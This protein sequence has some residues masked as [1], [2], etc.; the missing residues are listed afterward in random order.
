M[1][2]SNSSST[3]GYNDY[4]ANEQFIK[5][6]SEKL[7]DLVIVFDFKKEKLIYVNKRLA[8]I[9]NYS[10]DDLLSQEK[11]IFKKLFFPNEHE[12]FLHKIKDIKIDDK[13][14][15]EARFKASSGDIH[16][17]SCQI[18]K[19]KN[20][21]AE[22]ILISG[23]EI[24]QWKQH[25]KLLD[26]ILDAIPNAVFYK[27]LNGVYKKCNK[28]YAEC[29]G[30][31]ADKIIDKTIYDIENLKDSADF[32]DGVD[33]EVMLKGG[34]MEYDYLMRFADSSMHNVKINKSAVIDSD[35][36]VVGIVGVMADMTGHKYIEDAY[37]D[38]NKRYRLLFESAGEAI[39]MHSLDGKITEVNQTACKRLGYNRYELVN[40]NIRDISTPDYKNLFNERMQQLEKDIHGF[41][42]SE[43]LTKEGNIIFTEDSMR[44]FDNV[45]KKT[46]LIISRDVTSQVQTQKQIQASLEE[47]EIL[48]KE[49][50]H[51]VKNNFQIITSLLSLQERNVHNDELLTQ[52]N[53]A[54]NRIR[55]MALIHEKLYQSK[56]FSKI[57]M[58]D[59]ITAMSQE[60]YHTYYYEL[61]EVD[62][63][64]D[65]ENVL[66]ELDKAIPCGLII[67]EILTNAFKYA[68]P[69]NLSK[70]ANINI[71][72]KENEDKKVILKIA[73]NGSG[74]PNE[75][76]IEKTETLGLQLISILSGQLNGKHELIRGEGTEWIIEF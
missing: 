10:L 43:V 65:M 35:G 37:E 40:M 59:Y 23:N 72:L 64:Y 8:E 51:R 63:I 13:K 55:S 74:I 19:I 44:I 1:E 53:D 28:E 20:D 30:L 61:K 17:F 60:L 34:K 57:N 26:N 27:D 58:A 48:L 67:N 75:I 3:A 11:D 39:F 31:S 41:Y 49:I 76:D 22:Q 46:V 56:D 5:T 16:F 9:L 66:V 2:N 24:T 36:E 68:F 71:S 18:S 15:Y 38:C 14:V 25:D 21:E 50:H 42:R 7:T 6:L 52:F 12:E 32:H 29:I 47:K 73:D 4:Q 70:K 45:G 62:L 33:K 54:K 69:K